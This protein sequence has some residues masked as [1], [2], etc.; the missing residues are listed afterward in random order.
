MFL[1]NQRIRNALVGGLGGF[2]GWLLFSEPLWAP[3]M[4]RTAGGFGRLL[5]AD[6]LFGALF[7]LGLGLALGAAEGLFARSRY[8]T[9]R[10]GLIG[11]LAGMVGGAIGLVVGELVYQPLA[12]LGFVGRSIGW[13]VFGA[14]LGIA[15]GLIRRSWLG[16]RSAFLGGLI[17]GTIG[18]FMFDLVG[19]TIGL[20][21]GSAAL[22]RGVALTILG[23]C[24]G[25][26]IALVERALAPALLKVVSGPLEGRE[27]L[28]DK[29]TLVLGS[30]ERNDIPIF[31]D[32]AIR[33]RHLTLR[34]AQNTYLAQAEPGAALAVNG[35][36]AMQQTLRH[37]DQLLIGRTRFLFR[38]KTPTATPVP[39]LA[40]SIDQIPAPAA[41]QSAGARGMDGTLLLIDAH[42]GRRYPL[43]TGVMRIGRAPD[44]D[45]VLDDASVSG[46]HAEIRYEGGRYL[47]Y[48]QASSNGAYVNG[49]RL[50]GPNLIKA[51]WQIQLG[52]SI[53]QVAG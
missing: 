33:Q 51:G 7:G 14:L 4:N 24:I 26:W 36:T 11:A 20:L 37:E 46:Y 29:P 49:R 43:T 6:A 32:P 8:Q 22:S 9:Q 5:V 12:A 27:F 10:G 15:Q 35:Q 3:L 30:D 39:S 40:P 23:A 1:N 2:I 13:A 50:S 18:G 53:L 38:Q 42:T 19:F 31:G 48:D 34:S 25:L 47:L 52:D 28:L 16:V 21:T 17:G 44:N 41:T 45:I